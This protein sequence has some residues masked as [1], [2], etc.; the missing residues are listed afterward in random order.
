MKSIVS[1]GALFALAGAA[2]ADVI[3]STSFENAFVGDQYVDTGD[4]SVD[5]DLVN[6]TGQSVV[7]FAFDGVELGFDAYYRNTRNDVGLTDGDFVGASNFTGTVG[8]F[9]DGVQGYQLQ[10]A[11]GTMGVAFDTVSALSFTDLTLDVFVQETGW[12]SDDSIRI[13]AIVDGGVE[14]DIL[15]TIGSDV[16]DLF[17]EGSW[18]NLSLDLSSYTEATLVVEL[19]SNSGSESVYL[20]NIAFNGTA[21]PTPGSFALLAMGGLVGTRRRRA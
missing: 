6:N 21:I 20:D 4:A 19:E 13:F 9:T 16:D 3:A 7:D 15:N 1:M 8:S 18:L 5:H 14:L 17:I 11:D 12:E 10:D 2:H